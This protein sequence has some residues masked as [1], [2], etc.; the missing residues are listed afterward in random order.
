MAKFRDLR[1]NFSSGLLS[2]GLQSRLDLAA[3]NNGCQLLTNWWPLTTGGMRRRPGS[4][5]LNEIDYDDSGGI[6]FRAEPFV[7]NETQ[8]YIVVFHKRAL[9]VYDPDTGDI[10]TE[11][12]HNEPDALFEIPWF[13][14]TTIQSISV[15][16]LGDTMFISHPSF[17]TRKLIRE[18]ATTFDLKFYEFEKSP[19]TNT[20]PHFAPFWNF[21]D[22][23]VTLA[24][25]NTTGVVTFT[26]SANAFDASYPGRLMHYRDKQFVVTKYNSPTEIVG[27][28]KET[29]PGGTLIVGTVVSQNAH[30]FI[31]GEIVVGR[32]TGIKAEVT[33]LEPGNAIH[34]ASIAGDFSTSTINED[35]EGLD[36]GN[37]MT[38]TSRAP[39]Q[40]PPSVNW[41]EIAF[42]D[43]RGWPGIVTFH[44]QRLWFGGSSSLP[45]HIFGSK[46]AAF[47]NFD[48]GDGFPDESIQALIADEQVST[49]VDMVSASH[50]QIFTD[51]AEF[52]SPESD[53]SPLTPE[54]FNVLPQTRFGIKTGTRAKRLDEGTIFIQSN[55]TAVREFIWSDRTRSYAADAISLLSEDAI[56]KVQEVTVLYGGYERPEHI[57]FFRNHERNGFV[58]W[59]HTARS[60]QIRAWGIWETDHVP[61]VAPSVDTSGSIAQTDQNTGHYAIMAMQDKLYAIV[62]R[63]MWDT[64]AGQFRNRAFLERYELYSTLDC[65]S[66][67]SSNAAN[68][69]VW[70]A[71]HEP[72]ANTEVHAV[73]YHWHNHS[74]IDPVDPD[75]D[76]G[77]YTLDES[78]TLTL[79]DPSWNVQ[80]GL[81]FV[82]RL[83]PMPPEV[84]LS[85]GFTVGQP[86]RIVSTDIFVNSTL[87]LKIGSEEMLVFEVTDEFNEI[88][89]SVGEIP[90][91]P[92][93]QNK[94]YKFYGLGYDERPT[95]TIINDK[96]LPCEVSGMSMEVEY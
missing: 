26:A 64:D 91:E 29:L 57:A 32:D 83:E 14:A 69:A 49:I 96:P 8:R 75:Y 90:A 38:I 42:S 53:D 24:A 12:K 33:S 74:V 60:E 5:Y 25:S 3:Y 63:N 9:T 88:D 65:A 94:T 21:S 19:T 76:L 36:S 82:Q 58:S 77:H 84:Q 45:A 81:N 17:Q 71:L 93:R 13:N 72:L 95:V 67:P 4:V 27:D 15:A 10:I 1:T 78:G 31:V 55:G 47:F 89:P 54:T 23:D 16:Q 40:P 46:F 80:V 59:Y 61:A 35:I 70:P 79:N 86:K 85:D 62:V 2:R 6:M 20:Y 92:T 37:I 22:P 52:Y 56:K 7:F 51:A 87:S 30:E 41:G 66:A 34:V 39:I 11:L 28:V 18:S 73:A 68:I 48:T 50:L 44:S 43:D